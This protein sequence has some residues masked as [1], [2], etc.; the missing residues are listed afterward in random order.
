MGMLQKSS[1]SEA[2]IDIKLLLSKGLW[3][4]I[5]RKLYKSYLP[6]APGNL[7]SFGL[8]GAGATGGGGGGGGPATEIMGNRF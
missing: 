6:S 8:G 1:E 3:Y 5:N 2:Q 7:R 4:K